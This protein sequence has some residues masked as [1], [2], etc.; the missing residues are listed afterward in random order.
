MGLLE[1]VDRSRWLS[2]YL[3]MNEAN[4]LAR[5]LGKTCC[6]AV[7]IFDL[8]GEI[9]EAGSLELVRAEI[10][11][12]Q[13]GVNA[14]LVVRRAGHDLAMV[15]HPADALALALRA[16]VPILAS[17]AALAHAC[18]AD[19]ELRGHAVRRWLDR[20]RPA[21]FDDRAGAGE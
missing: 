20:L 1:D 6:G 14:S 21:D 2:F 4:R 8:L 19:Q 12:D 5:V 11:G 9:A 16:N 10:D 13:Q 3:P 15:C 17:D 7:P 18:P